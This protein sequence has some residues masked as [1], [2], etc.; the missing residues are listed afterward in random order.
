MAI[1]FSSLIESI[2]DILELI[3]DIFTYFV[4]A[5][6]FV[7]FA[8]I[9]G[10]LISLAGTVVNVY[11]FSLA[12]LVFVLFLPIVRWFDDV[13]EFL[14]QDIG[15]IVGVTIV[16]GAFFHDYWLTSAAVVG[17][18]LTFLRQWIENS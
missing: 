4:D 12:Y 15:F 16:S 6:L 3:I 17:M 8:V 11:S 5:L 9:L 14:K 1:N 10:A 18:F 13:D 7:V 2:G